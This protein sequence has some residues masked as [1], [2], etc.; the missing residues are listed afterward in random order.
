MYD[1]PCNNTSI[2]KYFFDRDDDYDNNTFTSLTVSETLDILLFEKRIDSIFV[3]I[4]RNNNNFDFDT[5]TRNS[6]CCHEKL[7]TNIN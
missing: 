7:P 4:L 6:N 3:F 5:I 2:I 1:S